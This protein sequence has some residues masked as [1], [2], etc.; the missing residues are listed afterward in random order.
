MKINIKV[1]HKLAVSFLLVIA[2]HAQSTQNSNFVISLQ[3]LKKEG[4]D[5]LYFL[6]AG[7]HQTILQVDTINLGGHVEVYPS[8]PK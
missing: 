8:Y 5:E 2:R 6:H 1:S 7:K 4:R 3:Y